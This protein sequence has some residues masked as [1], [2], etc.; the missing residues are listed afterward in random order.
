MLINWLTHSRLIAM[1]ISTTTVN[2]RR[3]LAQ[4]VLSIRRPRPDPAPWLTY[5]IH[6]VYFG[7][8][9]SAAEAPCEW[10]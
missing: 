2:A 8:H 7:A 5:M 10:P 4:Q 9:C 1:Q 3:A 6:T